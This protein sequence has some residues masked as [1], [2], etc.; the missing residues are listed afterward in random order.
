[1]IMF[2]PVRLQVPRR[3]VLNLRADRKDQRRTMS[4][5]GTPVL[6]EIV[7]HFRLIDDNELTPATMSAAS[8]RGRHLSATDL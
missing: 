4:A 3:S 8:P 1:M 2:R 6:N 5:H 7:F